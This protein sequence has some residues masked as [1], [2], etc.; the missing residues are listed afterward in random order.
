MSTLDIVRRSADRGLRLALEKSPE[1]VDIF[2]HILDEISRAELEISIGDRLYQVAVNQRDIAWSELDHTKIVRQKL[3]ARIADL[4]DP[5]I[6]MKMV[7][8]A[9]PIY[10][11]NPPLMPDIGHD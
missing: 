3:E 2:Q 10:I 4:M 9:P 5:I 8:P 1:F 6:R 11:I 7:E